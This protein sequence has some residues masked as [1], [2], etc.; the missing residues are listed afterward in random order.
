MRSRRNKPGFAFIQTVLILAA[1]IALVSLGVDYGRVQLAKTE[2]RSAADAA[3]RAAASSLSTPS[4]ARSLAIQYAGANNADGSPIQITAADVQFGKWDGHNFIPLSTLDPSQLNAVHVTCARTASRGNAIPLFFAQ[5]I[6]QNTCDVRASATVANS[7][8]GYGLVGLDYI[9]MSGGASD[10]FW[11]NGSGSTD[12]TGGIASNGPIT[13]SGSA[14]IHGDAHPGVGQT[15]TGGIVMGSRTPLTAPLS[16]PVMTAGAF[17]TNNNNSLIP[18]FA[19]SN[20]K[21]SLSG[22]QS[23]TL[24]GGVYYFTDFSL[25]G[26]STVNFTGPATIYCCGTFTLSGGTGTYGNLAK[27]LTIYMV[28]TPSG[29]APGKVTLSG[30]SALYASVYAPL[31]PISISGGGAIYGAVV[32]QS[33]DM[34]GGSSIHYDLSLASMTKMQLV[35]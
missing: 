30:G 29:T 17:V 26:S 27:N 19:L 7:S 4:V 3:A 9:K 35:Q 18:H 20:G 12:N 34:S 22:S 25:S 6:G 14:T 33:V 11:S 5:V 8:T 16:Y 1:L 10:S 28:P 32:G 13:L 15:S 23:V 31:S 24:P 21:F 2:L